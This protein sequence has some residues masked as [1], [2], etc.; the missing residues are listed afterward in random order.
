[1]LDLMN[2][3]YFIISVRHWF[4][5]KIKGNSIFFISYFT[6]GPICDAIIPLILYPANRFPV[7]DLSD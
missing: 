7:V 1:M 2:T 5:A 4:M 6:T 3:L